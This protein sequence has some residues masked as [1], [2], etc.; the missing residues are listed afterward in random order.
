MDL[1]V[2]N[3]ATNEQRRL[4]P[5]TDLAIEYFNAAVL[6]AA[7]GKG[8]DHT[9]CH[10]GPFRVVFIFTCT[11]YV[12]ND[13]FA[14][15][16]SSESG[17]WG[18]LSSIHHPHRH[19]KAYVDVMPSV[20]VGDTLY[21]SSGSNYIYIFNYRLGVA[22]LSEIAAPAHFHG[23]L[24][25]IIKGEKGVLELTDMQSSG[26]SIHVWARQVNASGA[27]AWVRCRSIKLNTLLPDGALPSYVEPRFMARVSG[28]IEGTD[29]IFVGTSGNT[30]MV[31]LNSRRVTELAL[32]SGRVV[33]Y[34]TR[35]TTFQVHRHA[36]DH[37]E[38]LLQKS[39]LQVVRYFL[40]L[41][42]KNNI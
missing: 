30:Y 39:R 13:T 37:A 1:V 23:T 32:S 31:Q 10:G 42:T 33:P 28:F 24:V 27:A 11:R 7:A 17:T 4:S 2:W 41:I 20:L 36:Y 19:R 5:P 8:C 16:Y 34:P 12:Q 9:A 3:P 29:I 22:S 25:V 21:F 18:G 35:T 26:S 14:L 38:L 6:C 40:A 15:V